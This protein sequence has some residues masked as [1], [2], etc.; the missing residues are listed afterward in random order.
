MSTAQPFLPSFY[1]IDQLPANIQRSVTTARTARSTHEESV[2]LPPQAV[3]SISPIRHDEKYTKPTRA[4]P[5]QQ[6]AAVAPV[7]CKEE[8]STPED[9]K[10]SKMPPLPHPS[11][12]TGSSAP[13]ENLSSQFVGEEETP[14]PHYLQHLPTFNEPNA[15]VPT[16]QETDD[17]AASFDE[18]NNAYPFLATAKQEAGDRSFGISGKSIKEEAD[19]RSFAIDGKS[20]K[21]EAGDSI[22]GI[23]GKSIKQEADDPIFGNDGKAMKQEATV[24]S[25]YCSSV[26][27][28]DSLC[29]PADP[30]AIDTL[31]S[32]TIHSGGL[33]SNGS[34]DLD[35]TYPPPVIMAAPDPKGIYARK[36]LGSRRRADAKAADTTKTK[37]KKTSKATA[38]S[39]SV[40]TKPTALDILR[41]RGGL[42]NRHPG[43][44]SA[45]VFFLSYD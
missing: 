15:V 14:A 18:K 24:D 6:L 32:F 12:T 2:D 26:P 28:I 29:N 3:L 10:T 27:K 37:R 11:L 1:A 21:R 7:T 41:G 33:Y 19:D 35:E 38:S 16:Q 20:I 23:D 45:Y 39:G 44:G 34:F 36:V 30:N 8:V 17:M 22:F 25:T 43:K 31:D 9:D 13:I 42:T 5:T 4:Y 40:V